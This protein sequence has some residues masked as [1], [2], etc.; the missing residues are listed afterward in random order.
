M[1]VTAI[2]PSYKPDE[3]LA[4]VLRDLAAAGFE[5]IIVV[6]D[7]SGPEYEA[8]FRQA[9][10]YPQCVLLRHEVNR[11]KG[12]A[13]KTAF[14]WFLEHTGEDLGVVTV[15]GDGQHTAAD[16]LRC[17][18]ELEAH[19]DSLVL[20]V[21]QFDGADVPLRSRIG[22]QATI[23]C[24]RVLCGVGVSDTQTGL[25]AIGTDFLRALCTVP[26]DRYEFETNMLLATSRLG[27][28]IR[29]VPIRTV[30]LEQNATSHF[31]PLRDSL[32]IYRQI[33]R[34]LS[35][36]LG[37]TVLDVA[38]FALM[39][40][41]LRGFSA[42]LRLL[43]ATV[44][45]RAC[46]S[47]CNFAANRTLVFENQEHPGPAMVRYY[48]LCI[49]QTA[50]SY[51]GVYLLSAVLGLPSVAAKVITDTLLFFASFQ[52]QRRWVFAVKPRKQEETVH[53]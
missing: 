50:A 4:G 36:S 20:G 26:G 52:I 17:A 39:D 27:I 16:A 31:N 3:K 24:F 43:G 47:L 38:L 5:R 21:R 40:W 1:K 44:I 23:W 11:G 18:R 12:G 25:R 9:E 49:V 2:V 35:V 8:Y 10:G 45:A 51:G 48:L 53:V 19:P 46:S 6:D 33:F 29:E 15:D 14:A 13:L 34:F 7:G 37:S 41:L 42:E 22:N 28:P 32:A 30:Y